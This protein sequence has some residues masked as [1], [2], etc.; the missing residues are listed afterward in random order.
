MGS[1]A[2]ESAESAIGFGRRLQRLQIAGLSN[3]GS[4]SIPTAPADLCSTSLLEPRFGI[5]SVWPT[6]QAELGLVLLLAQGAHRIYS[7]RATRR[8]KT[9]D[10]RGND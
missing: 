8:Y 7:A 3:M 9:R 4:C 10:E 1:I 5:T 6:I 2:I